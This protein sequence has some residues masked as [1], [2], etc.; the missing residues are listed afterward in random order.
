MGQKPLKDKE[1]EAF[2][3]IRNRII[4]GERPPSI[5]E[6][7][8]SMGYN[9]PNAA[10][11]VLLRLIEAGYI[12]RRNNGRLQVLREPPVDAGQ[13]HTVAVPLVGTAP[14]GAPLLAEENVE[15]WIDVSDQLARPPYRYFLLRAM[16]T[17]MDRAGIQDGDL[18]LV[19]QQPT[20]ENGERVVALINDSTTIKIFRRTGDVVTLE[21]KSTESKHRPI[22]LNSDFQVQGVVQATISAGRKDEHDG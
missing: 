1:L 20:A 6:L 16:G 21:P 14:C 7:A 11:Y 15:A 19:R 9:S 22:F 8:D 18:V 2:W 3:I 17:S 12:Q 5:R 10:A 4:H 13:A